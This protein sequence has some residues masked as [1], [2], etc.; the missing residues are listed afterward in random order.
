MSDIK[1]LSLSPD[2]RYPVQ[3]TPSDSTRIELARLE[4]TLR[5]CSIFS[6]EHTC[7]QGPE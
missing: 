4:N 7:Q 3:A 6:A 1:V 5:G 2:G